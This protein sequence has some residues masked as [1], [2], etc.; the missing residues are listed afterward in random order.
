LSSSASWDLEALRFEV[1]TEGARRVIFFVRYA[2]S[3]FGVE[4]I[5]AEHLLLGLLRE[6]ESLVKRFLAQ[7]DSIEAIRKQIEN[8]TVRNEESIGVSVDLPLSQESKRILAYAAE[9][10]ERLSLGQ[11]GTIHLLLGLLRVENCLAARI[12]RQHGLDTS[13]VNK[14]FQGENPVNSV[15]PKDGFVPDP[16]TALRIAEAVWIP[17]FGQQEVETQRPFHAKLERD[18]WVVTSSPK[19]GSKGEVIVA[20][21]LR[22]AGTILMIGRQTQNFIT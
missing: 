2:T 16:A 11:I 17:I 22:S 18:I 1:Y 8:E 3:E 19:Q 12:L 14:E 21:I 15:A 13:I 4:C 5:E 20:K 9:E 6:D 7:G 10:S